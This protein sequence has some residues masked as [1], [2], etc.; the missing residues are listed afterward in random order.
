M[1]T[2][3]DPYTDDFEIISIYSRA[4]AIDDRVLVDVSDAARETG[5]RFPVALTRAAWD[6]CVAMTPAAERAG[7]DE[8]GRLHDV[9]SMLLWAI[10]R[11]R[12]GCEVSFEVLCV[13]SRARPTCIPL[14]AVAGPGD[15]AEPVMTLMLPE[16]S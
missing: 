5:L 9:L 7:C 12:R 4:H 6:L 14:R 2:Q 15:D 16:E 1:D 11:S 10:G 3:L 13:T 8:R